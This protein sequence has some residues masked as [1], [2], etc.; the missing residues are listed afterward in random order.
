MG[1]AV[2]YAFANRQIITNSIRKSFE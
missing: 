2:N 1:C